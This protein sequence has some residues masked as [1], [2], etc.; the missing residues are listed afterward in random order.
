MYQR[1][2]KMMR[3]AFSVMSIFGVDG[4]NTIAGVWLWK[5]QD[6]AFKVCVF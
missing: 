3:N 1:L 4:N 5:G 6:L 2:E